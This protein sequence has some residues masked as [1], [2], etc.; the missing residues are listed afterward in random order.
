M[1]T[2]TILERNRPRGTLFGV[3]PN[4]R[5]RRGKSGTVLLIRAAVSAATPV[6][7]HDRAVRQCTHDDRCGHRCILRAH[8]LCGPCRSDGRNAVGSG[9]RT[10]VTILFENLD[11]LVGPPIRLH[12]VSIQEKLVC[13]RRGGYCCEHNSLFASVL[14]SQAGQDSG[15]TNFNTKRSLVPRRSP[16]SRGDAFQSRV[17]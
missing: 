17:S 10:Y 12:L 4:S 1:W 11:V 8:R 6:A 15:F 14:D 3:V 7:H 9:E 16:A 2:T 5:T 13:D